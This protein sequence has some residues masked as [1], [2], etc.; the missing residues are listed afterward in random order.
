[1][2]GAAYCVAALLCMWRTSVRTE[3]GDYLGAATFMG[4]GVLF[5]VLAFLE[6]TGGS[7]GG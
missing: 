4:G 6:L 1:M 5:A 7:V 2:I 3:W